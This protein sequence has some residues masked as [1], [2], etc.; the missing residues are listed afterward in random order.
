MYVNLDGLTIYSTYMCELLRLNPFD[1]LIRLMTFKL[2]NDECRTQWVNNI[3]SYMYVLVNRRFGALSVS[4]PS[5]LWIPHWV[6]VLLA[7]LMIFDLCTS[8]WV[9]ACVVIL[10][11]TVHLDW[12]VCMFCYLD[13]NRV[14]YRPKHTHTHTNRAAANLV[15]ELRKVCRWRCEYM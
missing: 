11:T 2:A 3:H 6:W 13:I 7:P 4:V 15:T 1:I 14:E 5:H 9:S 10:T 8:E 12:I